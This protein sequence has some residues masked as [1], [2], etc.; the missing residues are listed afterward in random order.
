MIRLDTPTIVFITSSISNIWSWLWCNKQSQKQTYSTLKVKACHWCFY[1][2]IQSRK[3]FFAERFEWK[4]DEQSTIL[5]GGFQDHF[6]EWRLHRK[7]KTFIPT[8]KRFF[9]FYIR[10]WAAC[11]VM[12][13]GFLAFACA[14]ASNFSLDI[15]SLGLFSQL[16]LQKECFSTGCLL[17]LSVHLKCIGYCFL[18]C[19]TRS[20][21]QCFLSSSLWFLWCSFPLILLRDMWIQTYPFP[22]SM[23]PSDLKQTLCRTTYCFQVLFL[24][25]HDPSDPL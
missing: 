4:R 15:P 24:L 22:G 10:L 12:S 14:E 23:D 11:G 2:S 7:N 5:W 1:L 19:G 17:S 6:F 20:F 25:L 16:C 18:R 13:W 9:F 21:Q 3:F 8:L